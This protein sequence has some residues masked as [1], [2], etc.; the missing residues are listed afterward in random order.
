[1]RRCRRC[2]ETGATL[3]WVGLAAALAA[4]ERPAPPTELRARLAELGRPNLASDRKTA[5]FSLSLISSR[6]NADL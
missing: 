1:M 4:C 5:P 6:S 3:V 2:A